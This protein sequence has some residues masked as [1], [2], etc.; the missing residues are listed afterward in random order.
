MKVCSDVSI[1][2]IQVEERQQS[3]RV[4][5]HPIWVATGE[6][7][8]TRGTDLQIPSSVPGLVSRVSLNAR[9]DKH[10]EINIVLVGKDGKDSITAGFD[11][12]S[13]TVTRS[14]WLGTSGKSWT[15]PCPTGG[16]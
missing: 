12:R 11:L 8:L 4:D 15:A 14:S 5:W 7:S 2:R 10:T 6:H 3:D 13:S 9:H 1:T 16:S